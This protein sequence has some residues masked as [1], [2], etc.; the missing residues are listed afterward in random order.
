MKGKTSAAQPQR[1]ERATAFPR[2]PNAVPAATGTRTQNQAVEPAALATDLDSLLVSTK[3]AMILLDLR[4]CIRRFTPAATSLF[5]LLPSDIG[6][7]ISDLSQKFSDPTFLSDVVAVLEGRGPSKTEVQTR[8]GCWYLRQTLPYM[9]ASGVI[10]GAVVTFSDVAAE[11]IQEARLYAESIVNTVREPLVVLDAELCIHS[12]NQAFSTMFGVSSQ[13]AL[14]R[15]LR[16]VGGGAWNDAGLAPLLRSV[17]AE[18]NSLEDLE[19]HH[20]SATEGRRTLL[21]NARTLRRG[22]D[23]PNLIL[24]AVDDVTERRRIQTLLRDTEARSR[25]QEA[26]RQRQLELSNAFR[27]S[28]VGELAAGLAHE[29]NQPLASISNVV[30]ACTHYVRAGTAEP[31]KLLALLADAAEQSVRAAGIVAHLRSFVSKG[32]PQLEPI[33]LR[34]V[35]ANIPHLLKRELD[36]SGVVLRMALPPTPLRV[37][38]DAI[39]IEQVIVNLIQNAMDSIQEAAGAES[40]IELSATSADGMGQVAVRDTG[41]GVAEDAAKRMFEAFYTTKSDGLGMGLAISRTILEAHRGRIWIGAPQ[42]G[43]RGAVVRFAIPLHGSRR[44][45]ERVL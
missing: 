11:A 15:P 10:E 20:D 42:D 37:H 3:I 5:S 18:D 26:V 44:R 14:G 13:E 25:E 7:S 33:D 39:Q 22:D 30:E 23:R 9:S 38:A 17:L 34:D 12:V 8:E 2:P 31:A 32:E 29:L 35:V 6:R 36:R 1:R 40:L 45:K 21:L 27:V 41:T 19:V 43:G 24:V 28:T 16:D 4:L